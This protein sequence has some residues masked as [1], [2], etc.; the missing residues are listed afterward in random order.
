MKT[1]LG[2]ILGIFLLGLLFSISPT[3]SKKVSDGDFLELSDNLKSEVEDWSPE[4]VKDFKQ[5]CWDLKRI[6]RGDL[7]VLKHNKIYSFKPKVV[8]YKVIKKS[9]KGLILKKNNRFEPQLYILKIWPAS[10]LIRFYDSTV[11]IIIKENK[12]RL[13]AAELFKWE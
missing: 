12:A 9:P 10:R 3:D 6:S 7:I 2:S 1:F 11:S 13:Y 5:F 8:V 4:K